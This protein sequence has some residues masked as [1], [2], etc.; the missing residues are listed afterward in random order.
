LRNPT[1]RID[2][3]NGLDGV[4]RALGDDGRRQDTLSAS[5]RP[6]RPAI[7]VYLA[8]SLAG[9]ALLP[10]ALARQRKLVKRAHARRTGLAGRGSL[11]TPNCVH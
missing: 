4:L 6:A 10:S 3:A 9:L 2:L 1:D 5:R 7:L 8:I 11:P